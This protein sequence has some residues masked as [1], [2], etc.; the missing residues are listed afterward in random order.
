MNQRKIGISD[1]SLYIPRPEIKLDTLVAERINQDGRLKRHL[2]RALRTTGQTAIRFP[3]AWEDSTTMAAQAVRN[4][5]QRNPQLHLPGLRYLTVGTETGVDHSK[6]V[7]AY[8]EGMLQRSGIQIPQ[9]LSSFQVQHAC[10]GGTLSLLSVGALLSLGGRDNESGI[11]AT[12]DIA[13]Y[14][15]GGTAEI[16]QG[17]G[18][19]GMLVES[20][21]RL[22]E[23]DLATQGY[24]SRDVD[25]FFRPLGSPVA[26]VKGRYSMEC[27]IDNLEA[28]FL[29]HCERRSEHPARVLSDTDLFV[30]HTPFRNM[31]LDA[32]RRLL[33]KHLGLVNGQ[34][35]AFLEE[36]GFGAGIDAV[37]GVG[38]IYTGS[39]Y[40]VLAY[41]LAERFRVLGEGIVGKRV[42]L[43]SYG[44]GNTMIV[45]SARVAG[46]AAA[47]LGGWQLDRDVE[48]GRQVG[49]EEYERWTAGPYQ[50]EAYARLLAGAT[51]PAESFFLAGY[52]EDG[53]RDYKHTGDRDRIPQSEPSDD[54]YERLAV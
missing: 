41:S 37:A 2:E 26:Q 46:Q 5:I 52:R 50:G 20:D 34:S 33:H 47:V 38:N 7:S 4:L 36:R 28:A 40:L 29:D 24:C 30:L 10:A 14:E 53:Y 8:V 42:L 39:M 51:V 6:P 32:M 44:S 1:I 35:E 31:P 19:V 54:M 15:I 12:S 45:S 48:S 22:L 9:S 17:A 25:D 13:K 43:A 3:D 27:Y 11:V 16:T 21:P 18:A 23:L 49:M